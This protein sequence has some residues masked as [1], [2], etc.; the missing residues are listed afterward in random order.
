[1]KYLNLLLLTIVLQSCNSQNNKRMNQIDYKEKL[2]DLAIH[3]PNKPI[4]LYGFNYSNVNIEVYFN[5]QLFFKSYWRGGETDENH[6][7]N[8][9]LST[10]KKQKLKIIVKPVN[11]S[12]FN[13]QSYYSFY[14]YELPNRSV[15]RKDE[16]L[17]KRELLNYKTD[18]FARDSTG[19]FSVDSEGETIGYIKEKRLE[20]K[21]YNEKEFEFK[22]DFNIENEELNNAKDLRNLDWDS[23]QQQVLAEYKRFTNSVDDKKEEVFWGMWYNKIK[24]V[25]K[26]NYFI[27]RDINDVIEEAEAI[28]SQANFLALENYEMRFYDQG[29]LV[30]FES[31]VDDLKLKGKSPLIATAKQRDD[32]IYK[33][34]IQFYFY[35]PN[36]SDELKIMY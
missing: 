18:E 27:E 26:Y 16:W 20:G 29:R 17:G 36:D 3:K 14:L 31:T 33:L 2:L 25:T 10:N 24:N 12:V 4:Y 34:P 32:S 9:L 15:F 28:Y 6:F 1:M 5:N 8:H 22:A 21:T 23:L 35:M 11:D 30:C 13:F 19:G 7:V